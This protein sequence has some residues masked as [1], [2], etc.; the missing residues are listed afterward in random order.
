MASPD[1]PRRT[2]RGRSPWSYWANWVAG[3]FAVVANVVGVVEI[4]TTS[5]LLL[6]LI[7]GVLAML[8]GGVWLWR[9]LAGGHAARTRPMLAL[10]LL[11][12]LVGAGLVGYVLAVPWQDQAHS[13]THAAPHSP[14]SPGAPPGAAPDPTDDRPPTTSPTVSVTTDPGAPTSNPP[15]AAPGTTRTTT[16]PGGGPRDTPPKAPPT[17]TRPTP[18]QLYTGTVSIRDPQFGWNIP[19]GGSVGGTITAWTSGYQVWMS[20]REDGSNSELV[21][22]P[23]QVDGE[24]FVCSNVQVTGR[25][26]ASEILRVAVVSDAVGNQLGG[27]SRLPVES[28]YASDETIAYKG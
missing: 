12:M 15:G 26:G 20:A 22:G 11:L 19:T 24:T 2:V 4:A 14:D 1:N 9:L 21:Q 3:A 27:A 17:T 13:Q 25:S 8:A 28:A 18:G 7:A 16:A 5:R 10:N 6:S 23:C